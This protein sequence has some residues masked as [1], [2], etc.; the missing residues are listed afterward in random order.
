[1]IESER[2][3]ISTIQGLATNSAMKWDSRLHQACCAAS[4]YRT[5]ALKDIEPECSKYKNVTEDMLDSMVGELL[6]SACPEQPKLSEIC[7]K[8]P[9]L[10]QA[11]DWKAVSLS[12]AALDLIVALS[13][14]P[15]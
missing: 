14:N 9:K 4:A 10:T 8:L 13:D 1:M 7:S 2:L 15:K 3:L 11:K 5:K 6:E 12:G